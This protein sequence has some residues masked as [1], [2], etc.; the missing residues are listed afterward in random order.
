MPDPDGV[1]VDYTQRYPTI[2]SGAAV[3]IPNWRP[4]VPDTDDTAVHWGWV[5][6]PTWRLFL[7]NA[8]HNKKMLFRITLNTVFYA[9]MT[10]NRVMNIMAITLFNLCEVIHKVFWFYC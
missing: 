8:V 4:A 3:M 10:L 2:S 9:T 5:D 7:Q 1:V 6:G